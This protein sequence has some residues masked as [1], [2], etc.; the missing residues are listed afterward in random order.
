[1][2]ARRKGDMAG[3]GWNS[4]KKNCE[5]ASKRRGYKAKQHEL[6]RN[7]VRSRGERRRANFSDKESPTRSNNR[8]RKDTTHNQHQEYSF[9]CEQGTCNDYLG[10]FVPYGTLI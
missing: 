2:T 1:M 10:E 4:K 3:S 9:L 8:L 6:Q 7:T 5:E